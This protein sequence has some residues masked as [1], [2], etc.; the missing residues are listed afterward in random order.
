M[1][2]SCSCGAD[3]PVEVRRPSARGHQNRAAFCRIS[4]SSLAARSRSRA[5]AFRSNRW[6]ARAGPAALE[7]PSEGSSHPWEGSVANF[8]AGGL[9]VGLRGND[10]AGVSMGLGNCFKGPQ[11]TAEAILRAVR[12]YLMLPVSYRDLELMLLDRGVEVATRR[13]F[14]GSRPTQRSLKSE[15]AAFATAPGGWTKPTFG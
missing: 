7:Q 9:P 13:S 8:A 11:F 3:C 4:S 12:W 10:R 1:A 2:W 6:A 15:P 14:D 5:E